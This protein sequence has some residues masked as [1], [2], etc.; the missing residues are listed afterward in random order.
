L[1]RL[2]LNYNRLLPNAPKTITAL[3][4]QWEE[5][6]I[7]KSAIKRGT[8]GGKSEEDSS[9]DEEED[10]PTFRFPVS[11]SDEEDSSR[12]KALKRLKKWANRTTNN[13]IIK[14][15][16]NAIDGQEELYL[17][18][19]Q[20]TELPPEI[21]QLTNLKLSFHQRLANSQT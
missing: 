13:R 10:S 18:G 1:S 17:N 9:N 19:N 8:M 2:Y 11:D 4:Q 16:G 7:T 20:L 5:I 14:A 3:Q 12:K 15:I 6:P 21:G